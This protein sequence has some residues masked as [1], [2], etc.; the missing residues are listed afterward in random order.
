MIYKWAEGTRAPKGISAQ[1]AGEVCSELSEKGELTA[2]NLVEV[3]RP[4]D[5]PLHN[6]FEW[7]D[8]E[9]AE[10]W[11]EQQARVIISHIVIKSEEV[12]PVRAFFN[13]TSLGNNYEKFEVLISQEDKKA[14]L[15]AQAKRELQTFRRKYDTLKELSGIFKEIDKLEGGS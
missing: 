15:L 3:S 9:A 1:I 12:K 7:D 4:E 11:R 2:E 6:A 10:K 13:I 8:A 5:A 14:E